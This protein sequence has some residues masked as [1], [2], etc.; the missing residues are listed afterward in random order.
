ME[1]Y[2]IHPEVSQLG[3]WYPRGVVL[4]Q[5]KES[6]ISGFMAFPITGTEILLIK[7]HNKFFITFN[8]DSSVSPQFQISH[9][10]LLCQKT[11]K[12]QKKN[13]VVPGNLQKAC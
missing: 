1:F 11:M 12:V 8:S 13:G 6:N 5:V 4:S 10:P 3:Y 2:L 9:Y 7:K